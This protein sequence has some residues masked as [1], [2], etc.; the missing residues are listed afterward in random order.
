[1]RLKTHSAVFTQL[2]IE[3]KGRGQAPPFD[4]AVLDEA[5][6][7]SVAQLKFLAAMAG[8]R[9]NGLFFAGDLGQRIFQSPFSWKSLGV[10]VRGR[11]RTLHINYRMSHQIRIQADKLLGPE[12]ADVDGCSRRSR[13]EPPCRSNSEPGRKLTFPR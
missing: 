5:Q 2:A 13:Y 12:V 6:D 8:S 11:S 7:V 10:D 3:L 9:P 1:L 4:F